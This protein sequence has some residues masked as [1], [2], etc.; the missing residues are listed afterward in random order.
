[1]RVIKLGK[2][3]AAGTVQDKSNILAN[4]T[5]AIIAGIYLDGGFKHAESFI[6][7]FLGKY[8]DVKKLNRLDKNYKSSLQEY[9]QKHYKS[10]PE[11]TTVPKKDLFHASVAIS[12]SKKGTGW[13]KNKREAEQE[14]A[15]NLLKKLKK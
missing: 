14:A 5:E 11:Y 2:G 7:K 12:K 8:L 15:H 4:A 1:V 3:K 6:L 13:G 9:S 10:L